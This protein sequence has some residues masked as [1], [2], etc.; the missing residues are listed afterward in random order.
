MVPE[1]DDNKYIYNP[2]FKYGMIEPTANHLVS[3]GMKVVQAVGQL[4]NHKLDRVFKLRSRTIKARKDSKS[5][6]IS[7][8]SADYKDDNVYVHYFNII[9]EYLKNLTFGKDKSPNEQCSIL[10]INNCVPIGKNRWEKIGKCPNNKKLDSHSYV[11]VTNKY[12]DNLLSYMVLGKGVPSEIIK[13]ITRFNP[14]SVGENVIKALLNEPCVYTDKNKKYYLQYATDDFP[15][16][17]D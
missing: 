5:T 13:D 17:D 4:D 9:K 12:L 1:L 6:S 8:R 15:D 2:Y 3:G 16:K 14:I 7:T 10:D 11:D